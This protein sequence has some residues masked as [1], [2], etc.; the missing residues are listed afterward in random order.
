MP[1]GA[2][3]RHAA[4]F[5]R[6]G[7]AGARRRPRWGMVP[8]AMGD[9]TDAKPA[10]HSTARLCVIAISPALAKAEGAVK[11]AALQ[12]GE[13]PLMDSTN[14]R[15]PGPDPAR[16]QPMAAIGRAMQRA[17]RQPH[18]P[19]RA[20]SRCVCARKFAAG[21]SQ[22]MLGGPEDQQTSASMRSPASA[23][24]MSQTW[25]VTAAPARR[26]LPGLPSSQH[27]AAAAT[28]MAS[29]GAELHEAAARCCGPARCRRRYSARRP[30][31]SRPRCEKP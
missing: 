31:A 17:C 1:A 2:A 6:R 4:M 15:R 21:C 12:G 20:E 7:G 22:D 30:R 18:P 25:V 24:R 27:L 8:G 16:P 28:Q 13:R 10:P 23:S 11:A 14:A 9:Q 5:T 26:P 3:Q 19:P 29:R